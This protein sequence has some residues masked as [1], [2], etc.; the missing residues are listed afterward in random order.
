M[1]LI[2]TVIYIF[3]ISTIFISPSY[4]LTYKQVNKICKRERDYRK[5]MK[6]KRLVEGNNYNKEKRLFTPTRIKVIPF[7]EKTKG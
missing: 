1:N 2:K 6:D 5:C 3:T 7:K 4:S